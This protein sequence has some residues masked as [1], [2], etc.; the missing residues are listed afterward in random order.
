[1]SEEG[2]TREA[3]AWARKPRVLVVE[4][5]F[6]VSLTLRVQLEA[7][8]CEVVGTAR[9][10][11]TAVDLAAELRPDVILMDI[12]LPG[13]D[14]VEATREIMERTPTPII[15][16]TAYGDERVQRALAAGARVALTKPVLEEQL[17]QALAQVRGEGGW[18]K[19]EGD[20]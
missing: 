18:P 7:V 19:G 5:E 16:V 10:A 13:K 1:M 9:E 12:G 6:V 4:D 2:E 20:S 14:G 8:G 17:A 15:V 3:R 11:D